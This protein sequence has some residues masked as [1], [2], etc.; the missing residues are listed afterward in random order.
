MSLDQ[1]VVLANAWAPLPAESDSGE[2]DYSV[3]LSANVMPAGVVPG[4]LQT[5]RLDSF[6]YDAV[7]PC[8]TRVTLVTLVSVRSIFRVFLRRP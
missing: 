1:K 7:K 8:R 6:G 3:F 5:Y 2:P 4:K